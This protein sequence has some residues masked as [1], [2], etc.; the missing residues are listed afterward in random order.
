MSFFKKLMG[1]V[2]K[3]MA[4]DES[5]PANN[6]QQEYSNI[7]TAREEEENRIEYDPLTQHG[8][9]YSE[10]D[11][12][13][14]VAHRAQAWIANNKHDGE[15]LPQQDVDNIYNNFRDELY[16]QLNEPDEQQLMLWKNTN[17]V[18]Y[19]GF[20]VTG[21][22]N[23]DEGNPLLEPIHGITLKDY[24]AICAKLADG[25]AEEEICKALKLEKPVL[26]EVNTL[27]VKRMQEDS[28]FTI[29]ALFGQY[30]GEAS[31][32]PLLGQLKTTQTAQ[33]SE[34]LERFKTDRYYYEEL[35]GARQ[36]AY[37][38]GIDG[39][40]WI[41]DN[42]GITLGDFQSVAMQ[43]ATKDNQTADFKAIQHFYNYRDEK[44]KEYAAKF[45]AEMGGNVADDVEF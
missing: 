44:Q 32:H 42:Y 2:N 35:N 38:Y 33:G 14:E 27:W 25:I 8:T 1:E 34:N 22:V 13:A 6:R 9:H 19:T 21:F 45:A 17:A 11:F 26:D 37:D 30:F 41:A 39:A 15:L 3:L 29:S 24:G 12:E 16:M 10:E 40:Q 4:D 23:E 36:A 31:Q 18:K 28:T 43:W 7:P 20:A 5:K